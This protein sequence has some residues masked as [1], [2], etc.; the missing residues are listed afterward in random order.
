MKLRPVILE[1]PFAGNVARNVAYARACARHALTVH[2]EAPFLSHLLYTQDGIL[3]DLVLSERELGIEAGLV[4]GAFAQKTVLYVDFGI[5]GG[6][7]RGIDRALSEGRLV[8]QRTLSTWHQ[9]SAL[10]SAR[11]LESQLALKAA[12]CNTLAIELA[13][14]KKRHA[15]LWQMWSVLD[16]QQRWDLFGS[17]F[18]DG[19]R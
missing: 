1:S 11:S 9:S 12:E 18:E 13:L 7:Q 5:S 2:H 6:M 8:E 14:A 15:T 3:D 16:A 4:W 10:S 17:I 19:G